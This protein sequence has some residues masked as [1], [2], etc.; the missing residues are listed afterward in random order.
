MIKAALALAIGISALSANLYATS[1]WNVNATSCVADA[2]SIQGNLYLGTGGTVKFASGKTGNI[3]LYCPVSFKLGFTP[4]IIGMVY[5]DDSSSPG[6]HV[7]AQLVKMAM[8]TGAI[9]SVVTVD[10][11]RGPV[12]SQG[13]ANHVAHEFTNTYDPTN[14]AYYI[15]IDVTRN[16][17]TA[18][19]TVYGVALQD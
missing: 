11:D 14:F 4:S 1:Q 18:N 10:S 12:T 15:R 17:A 2:G 16:S 13:K 8:D 5:Y 3:V 7:T 9:T 19:E 6:N